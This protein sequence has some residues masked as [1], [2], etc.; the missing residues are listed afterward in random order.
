MNPV[1]FRLEL[2]DSARAQAVAERIEPR[3]GQL[4]V[5]DQAQAEAEVMRDQAIEVTVVSAAVTLVDGGTD[6]VAQARRFIGELPHVVADIPGLQRVAVVV[7]DKDVVIDEVTDRHLAT[8][9]E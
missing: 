5:V 6:P 9:M 7:G 4:A 3:L 8:I 1:M 2:D